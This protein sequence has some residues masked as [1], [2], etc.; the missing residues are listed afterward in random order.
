MDRRRENTAAMIAT[1]DTGSEAARMSKEQM[2]REKLYQATMSIV[3]KMLAEG[4]ITEE[5]YRQ[6]DTMFL[7]KY[8]PLFGALCSEIR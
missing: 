2:R 1:S 5:E 3:R 8:R 6:I 7:A 4:L